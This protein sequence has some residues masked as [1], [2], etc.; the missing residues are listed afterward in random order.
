M[1]LKA[2]QISNYDYHNLSATINKYAIIDPANMI[3]SPYY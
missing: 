3:W 1:T 2:I